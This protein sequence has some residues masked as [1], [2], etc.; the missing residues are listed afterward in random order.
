VPRGISPHE[1][2]MRIDKFLVIS[3]RP[4]D[5]DDI[6]RIHEEYCEETARDLVQIYEELGGQ[7]VAMPATEALRILGGQSG[8][9]IFKSANWDSPGGQGATGPNHSEIRESTDSRD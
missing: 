1:L 5:G 4:M 6:V 2:C 3:T 9:R 7:A 8:P